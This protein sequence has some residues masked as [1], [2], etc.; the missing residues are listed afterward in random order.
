MFPYRDANARSARWQASSGR[1]NFTNEFYSGAQAGAKTSQEL[2][3]SNS[4]GSLASAGSATSAR[5]GRPGPSAASR[6]K[7]PASEERESSAADFGGFAARLKPLPL[8]QRQRFPRLPSGYA[9]LQAAPWRIA[10]S[11]FFSR[12][13]AAAM[14]VLA[15]AT[16]SA[17]KSRPCLAFASTSSLNRYRSDE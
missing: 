17:N 1:V 14:R 10:A 5:Q 4:A 11:K 12:R 6:P 13:S 7:E 8:T 2:A 16:T 9:C 3:I 15:T